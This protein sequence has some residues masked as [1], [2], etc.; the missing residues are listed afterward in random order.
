M[1]KRKALGKQQQQQQGGLMVGAAAD[2]SL[3]RLLH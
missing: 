3:F 1:E 2:V